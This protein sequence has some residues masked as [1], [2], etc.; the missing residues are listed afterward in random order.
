MHCSFNPSQRV[1]TKRKYKNEKLSKA[2]QNLIE[3][4]PKLQSRQTNKRIEIVK[5]N[6]KNK[7]KIGA[8]LREY[9]SQKQKKHYHKGK[10]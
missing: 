10:A 1:A 8:G 7:R 3:K 9:R 6:K 4:R 2:T 5:L